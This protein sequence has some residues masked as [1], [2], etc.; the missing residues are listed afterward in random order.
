MP[1]GFGGDTTWLKGKL[2][3][4]DTYTYVNL[5]TCQSIAREGDSNTYVIQ[6]ASGHRFKLTD[7]T[8][9]DNLTEIEPPEAE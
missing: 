3:G 8:N 9:T 5:Y 7:C 1:A 6:T 2:D 4:S